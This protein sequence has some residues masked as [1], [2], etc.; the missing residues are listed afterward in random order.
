MERTE[1]GFTFNRTCLKVDDNILAVLLDYLKRPFE[2][3]PGF[4][5]GFF[6]HDLEIV[7]K[8]VSTQCFSVPSKIH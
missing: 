5:R 1:Y 7:A 4:L 3:P 2:E 6:R 8:E